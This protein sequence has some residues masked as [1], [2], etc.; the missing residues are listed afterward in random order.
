MILLKRLGYTVTILFVVLSFRLAAKSELIYTIY[1]GK[2]HYIIE[3]MK[4]I[5]WPNEEEITNFNVV[6]LGKNKDLL[7]ALNNKANSIIRKKSISIQQVEYLSAVNNNVDV[8]FISKNFFSLIPKIKE[9]HPNTL[10]ISDGIAKKQ[11]LMVGL[12]I[13]KKNMRLT[14]NR[15]HLIEH[16][17]KVSNGLLDF[18]GTKADLRNEL[19][20][21]ENTLNDALLDAKAKKEQLLELNLSLTKNE[22]KLQVIQSDLVK[23]NTLLVKAQ[24]ELNSLKNDKEEATIELANKKKELLA[25]QKLIFEKVNEHQKLEL[26]QEQEQKLNQLKLDVKQNEE[27]LAQQINQLKQQSNIIERKEQKISGQRKLLYITIAV[28]VV[29]LLLKFIVLKTSN[30]RKQANKDLADLN[31]QLYELATKDDMTKLFN[32][33]HFL[34]LAQREVNQLHRTKNMGVVLM[35]DIDHFKDVND[36][37]G[38]AAG[39]QAIINVANILKDNLREYDIVGRVGGEE[40]SMFLPNSDIGVSSQIAERIRSKVANSS[41]LFK[42]NSISITISIG[43]TTRKDNENSI[44]SML[45]RADKALYQAK[46]S[47]RNKVVSL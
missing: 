40:F 33:R 19:N 2:A 31:Q 17:F 28:A 43:L 46:N 32:R 29:I 27:K 41:T 3:V 36:N 6:I 24:T 38:H 18:A 9:T 25:K 21:R 35:I 5:T 22:E 4:H 26:E 37:Y 20:E 8:I 10:I 30:R 1:D 12:L 42:E 45:H 11:D 15:E 7:K 23:Q 13:E 34:E 14:L 44:D 39:D 16:G 47:G